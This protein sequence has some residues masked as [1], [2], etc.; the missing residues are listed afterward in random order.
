MTETTPQELLE[1]AHVLFLDIVGYTRYPVDEQKALI[2]LLGSVV[3]QSPEF[4]RATQ[5][6]KLIRLHSG[7]GMALVFFTGPEWPVGCAISIS[8][9]LREEA[10]HVGVRM[11]IHT[12]AVYRLLDMSGTPIVAGNGINMAQRVMDAGDAGHILLSE[13]VAG[14]LRE[15]GTWRSMLKDL[16]ECTVKH[17]GTIR[18]VNLCSPGDGIGNPEVPARM[19]PNGSAPAAPPAEPRETAATV[20]TR[21]TVIADLQAHGAASQSP[22]VAPPEQAP[23]S[24]AAPLDVVLLYKRNSSAD[25]YVLRLLERDLRALGHQVFIDR[26]LAV[27]VEWARQ[28]E[29][30]VTGADVVIALLSEA[31]LPSEML[32][33][34]IE[35]AHQAREKRSGLPRILPVRIA[36]EGPLPQHLSAILDPLEYT[37]WEGPEHDRALVQALQRAMETPERPHVPIP[38]GVPA[39]PMETPVGGVPPGSP[40]YVERATDQ[41]FLEALDRRESIILVNGAR[42]MGKTSLLARGLQQAREKQMRVV[43]T[44]FQTLSSR[45]LESPDALFR[46][47]AEY[48]AE[49]LDLDVL[50]EG[51]AWKSGSDPGV[52]L[53]RYM[54]RHVLSPTPTPLVWAMD[55]VDRLFSCSFG[56][57][58]FGLFRSWHNARALDPAGPWSRLTLAISYATEAQLFITDIN[59]SPFNVGLKVSLDDFSR[60][61]VADLNARYESPLRSEAEISRFVRLVRGQPYLVRRGLHEMRARSCSIDEFERQA[62]REDGFYGDH[63]RRILV[64]LT[65]HS[66]LLAAVRG[67][68]RD[69]PCADHATFFSLRGLGIVAGDTFHDARLRCDL[70]VNYLERHL[71]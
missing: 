28:I 2:R 52:N 20:P 7:D 54:R 14:T 55:E 40:Y 63:L 37:L 36:Y 59:Q 4:Q 57:E 60:A 16:G 6:D 41:Q 44:D 67:M 47:L 66:D 18:L 33:A 10:P 65:R 25:E 69:Q 15:V 48:I 53:Q 46:V 31:A 27:G 62:D 21:R 61:Q 38:H 24:A 13:S 12:G 58:V 39:A 43:L 45:H 1:T 3:K 49:Q 26:H 11:G 42:Q 5:P 68:L 34:E 19:A 56:S 50:P 30:K 70:Y 29:E 9:A 51:D 35:M 32:A 17:G 8:R 23:S 22:Q 71:L 64:V